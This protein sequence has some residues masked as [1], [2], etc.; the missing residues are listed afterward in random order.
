MQ[1]VTVEY[2]RLRTYGEYQNETVGAVAQVNV[3]AGETADEALYQ[4]RA[5][6]DEQLGNRDEQRSL[7][8]RVSDLRWKADD[9]ERKIARLDERWKA[10]LA[11]LDKLGLERPQDIPETLEGLPF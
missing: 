5:W 7:E 4:L 1:I 6:V 10:I 8:E 9:Y 2:R 11:F 3:S